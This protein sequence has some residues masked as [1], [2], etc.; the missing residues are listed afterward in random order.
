[1]QYVEFKLISSQD[2]RIFLDGNVD[3][4]TIDDDEPEFEYMQNNGTYDT[5]LP[6]Y[7]KVDGDDLSDDFEVFVHSIEWE[8]LNQFLWDFRFERDVFD[9]QGNILII[10]NGVDKKTTVQVRESTKLKLAHLGSKGDSF[11]DII[12]SLLNFY[13]THQ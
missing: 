3:I 1:M 9:F 12:T 2:E 13:K 10:N 4:D 5:H 11:D 6:I 7:W 8:R